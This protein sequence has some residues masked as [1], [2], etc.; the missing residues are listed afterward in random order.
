LGFGAS[1]TMQIAQK[2]YQGI[3]I[4]GETIGLITYMR[5]DGTNLSADAIN[6]F[7]DYIK[8]NCGKEYLPNEPINY[9]GKKAKNAQEAHEAI[10]PTD[11][12]R[13]P[14]NIKKYLS[15]DQNKLYELI[16]SRAL[17]SQMESAQFDRSTISLTSND[18]HT[19]C[20]SS[21]S[22]LKF[23]GFLKIYKSQSKED[24]EEI[25]PEVSKGPVNIEALIDEQHF[26]TTTT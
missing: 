24:D 16:W 8:E 10:R 1:R 11:I 20:K 19:I 26:Y 12:S 14:D 17:S 21:G 18:N 13:S 3:E 7:R 23:D 22:I 15:T 25:L 5:T 9:S 2:L 6:T 4:E